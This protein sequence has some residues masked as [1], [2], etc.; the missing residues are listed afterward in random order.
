ML[1]EVGFKLNKPLDYYE[2]LL[3]TNGCKNTWNNEIHDTYYT[4]EKLDGM[5]ENEMKNACIRL[6]R[7][8]KIN[9]D[10]KEK[11]GFQN[12]VLYDND[13]P[14]APYSDELLENIKK[15]GFKQVFD[16]KKLDIHYKKEGCNGD[17]QLQPI[18]NIGLLVYY[19]NDDYKDMPFENQRHILIDELNSV[20]FNFSYDELGLDKLR[21]LYYET[22]MFSDNQNG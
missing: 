8:K 12:L 17:I 19:Y 7:Y 9:S 21:T 6:R 13:N 5:T 15:A 16:T 3:K 10:E 4:K 20:G 2:E 1:V 22:E 11:V 18:E 14:F